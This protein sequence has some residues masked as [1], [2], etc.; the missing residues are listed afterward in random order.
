MTAVDHISLVLHEDE[1]S[2]TIRF[3]SQSTPIVAPVL[4]VI[5]SKVGT[6]EQV[7]L[8]SKIHSGCTNYT[9]WKA[10][11]VISTILTPERGEEKNK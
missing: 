2:A 7:Y 4:A 10:D 6:I 5:R 9:G 3:A 8:R 1:E 11:G